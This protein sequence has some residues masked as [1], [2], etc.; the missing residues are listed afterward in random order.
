MTKETIDVKNMKL[1]RAASEVAKLIIGKHLTDYSPN[2]LPDIQIEVENV[3]RLQFSGRKMIN[4]KYFKH[5]GYIGNLKEYSLED[6]YKSNPEK[7]FKKCV[8]S[9]LPKNKLADQMIKKLIIK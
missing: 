9:M 4:K 7:L 1:G 3:D 5:S 6:K 8:K 2:K